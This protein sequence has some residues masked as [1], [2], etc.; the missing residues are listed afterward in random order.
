MMRAK[1]GYSMVVLVIAITVILILATSVISVLQVSREKTEVT[2]FIFDMTTMEEEVKNFYTKTGTLPVLEKIE[3]MAGLNERANGILSQLNVYDNDNYYYVDLEQLDTITLKDAERKYIVNEGSLRI[4][5]ED[6][7][8]YSDME[9][10]TLTPE[11]VK[12]FDRYETQD[13]EMV[14]VGNPI[15]WTEKASLRLVLPRKSLESVGAESWNSWTFKWD[16]GP[17][18]L[19]EMRDIPEDGSAKNFTYGDILTVKSN[20]IYTIYVKDNVGNENIL[21]VNITKIDEKTPTYELNTEGAKTLLQIVDEETGI[22]AL[23][24][25]A[26]TDYNANLAEA[27]KSTAEDLEG[28]TEIDFYLLDGIGRDIIY[29]LP[30][31]IANFKAQKETIENAIETEDDRYNRWKTENDMTLLTPEE[32]NMENKKHL[33]LTTDL[34]NQLNDLL[35]KYAY[36]VDIYGKTDE[37]RLVVYVEDYAGNATVIGDKVVVSTKIIADS[38][39]I[40]LAGLE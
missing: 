32:I 12:G 38:Y 14:V 24:Y 7:V 17:K 11:L 36:L 19:E 1:K 22:K 33:D 3:D 40:S 23:K 6:G 9:Y 39:N 4:Y 26:L 16:F 2:N 13:E 10:Y 15:T 37:S 18:T 31:E 20:G 30:A 35:T 8:N 25:K 28:R 21:N 29:D 27:E 34:S 5:V